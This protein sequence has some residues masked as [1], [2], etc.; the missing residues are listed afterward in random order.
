MQW[1]TLFSKELLENWRNY[2]WVWFPL[3]F[4]LLAIMDPIT[5][6][7]LP[8]IMDS[9]GGL[10]EGTVIDMPHP[11]PAEAIMMSLGQLSSLGVLVIVVMLMGTIANEIKSGVAELV[12][13]KPVSY[14]NYIT[15]KWVTYTLMIYFAL[16]LGLT[17]SWYYIT[18]LFGP[19]DYTAV[20][21]TIFF[22]GLWLLFVLTITIFYNTFIKVPGLVAALSII[23]LV[24][25]SIITDIFDHILT[26]SPVKL[27]T[28]IQEMLIS[29]VISTDLIMTASIT[30]LLIISLL[31]GSIYIFERKRFL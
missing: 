25:I 11:A 22:F 31:I 14:T 9:V 8:L 20:L 1:R 12:L 10:P 24:A 29:N 19:L 23:T 4:V 7:Y 2:K 3:V 28:Y 21:Q 27:S 5:T 17:M 15:A 16:W 13:V 26:W 30:I 6:Y 18:I